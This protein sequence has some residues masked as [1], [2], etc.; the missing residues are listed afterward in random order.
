MSPKSWCYNLLYVMACPVSYDLSLTQKKTKTQI[1]TKML[2]TKRIS[3]LSKSSLETYWFFLWVGFILNFGT[4]WKMNYNNYCRRWYQD[5][6]P[7]VIWSQSKHLDNI[8]SYYRNSYSRHLFPGSFCGIKNKQNIRHDLE[9]SMSMAL[10][11][12]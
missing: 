3:G 12:N 11:V 8:N 6:L 10:L 2:T 4:K 7:S 1:L 5:R 9:I